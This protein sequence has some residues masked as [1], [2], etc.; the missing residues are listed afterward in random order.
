MLA[1]PGYHTHWQQRMRGALSPLPMA[2]GPW[3]WRPSDEPEGPAQMTFLEG[4]LP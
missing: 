2:A 3:I 4:F 1:E